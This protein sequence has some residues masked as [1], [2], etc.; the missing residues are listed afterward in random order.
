MATDRHAWREEIDDDRKRV[1]V[2]HLQWW[3]KTPDQPSH[4]DGPFT[5]FPPGPLTG[6]DVY[7]LVTT[8]GMGRDYPSLRR[9]A[10]QLQGAYLVGAQLQRAYLVGAQLQ[11]ALL[12]GAQLQGAHLDGA[13]LQGAHL[14]GAQLQGAYLDRAQLQ[15]AHLSHAT[16]D[17]ATVLD[18][19][20]LGD[21]AA[22]WAR[23]ADVHWGGTDLTV[24]P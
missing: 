19:V 16:L 9:Y 11:G 3:D 2:K 20:R 14:D 5:D 6:A 21:D 24:V 4:G 1:L 8:T 7:W 15:G 17:S 18:S 23:L 10:R 12:V 13:Q 22:G